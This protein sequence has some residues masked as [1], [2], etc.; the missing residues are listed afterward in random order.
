V[1]RSEDDDIYPNCDVCG[2]EMWEGS[3]VRQGLDVCFT[4]AEM[5]EEQGPEDAAFWDN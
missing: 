3:K 2:Y 4:C 1:Q 5:M